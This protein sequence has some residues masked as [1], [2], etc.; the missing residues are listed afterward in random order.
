MQRRTSA[1]RR[2][3]PS[4]LNVVIAEALFIQELFA[5]C[6]DSRAGLAHGD[7]KKEAVAA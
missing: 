2:E 6:L 3:R 7:R 5:K 1:S 4:F